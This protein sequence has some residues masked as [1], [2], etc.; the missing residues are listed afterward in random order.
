MLMAIYQFEKAWWLTMQLTLD[1]FKLESVSDID[2]TESV[3]GRFWFGR[4]GLTCDQNGLFFSWKKMWPIW[5]WL[6]LFVADFDLADTVC[7]RY[8]ISI[9]YQDYSAPGLF[10]PK[11]NYSAPGLFGSWIIQ[12][13][14]YSAPELFG[15]G[16][17]G[18]EQGYG[19]TK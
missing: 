17:I 6:Y 7:G 10:G 1:F 8:S 16:R 12:P 2:V 14:D 13:L 5:I 15:T 19:T 9:G 18:M 3:C 4:Y 11:V